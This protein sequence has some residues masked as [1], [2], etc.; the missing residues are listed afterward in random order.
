M[1]TKRKLDELYDTSPDESD[2]EIIVVK[3][4]VETCEGCKN[5]EGNQLCHMNRGGCLYDPLNWY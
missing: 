2:V 1:P 5:D 3:L 4:P